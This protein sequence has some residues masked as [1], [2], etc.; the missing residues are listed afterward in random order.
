VLI[1]SP[2]TRLRTER[3][4]DTALGAA[5]LGALAVAAVC[6][7]ACVQ[8]GASLLH[9]DAKAHLVVA[10]RAIDSLTPGW[11]QLGAVWLPLPHILN[12]LPAQYDAL[13]RTGLAGSLLSFGF[14][15]TGLFT[16]ALGARRATG[17]GIAGIVALSVPA[18][19]PGWLYLQSTPLIE[20]MYLGCVGLC[21]FGLVAWRMGGR[22]RS[23]WLA[24][25][26]A[27]LACWVRYEAWPLTALAMLWAIWVAPPE[28]RRR[29]AL[30]GLGAG[31]VG[32]ILLYGLHSWAAT[33]IPFYAIGSENLTEPR[34][35]IVV[36]LRRLMTGFESAFGTPLVVAGIIAAVVLIV[37]GRSVLKSPLVP[38]AIASFAPLSVTLT[39]YIAGHPSKARY[40][41]LSAPGLALL[42]AAATMRRPILQAAA[43]IVTC[44]QLLVAPLPLPIVREATWDRR[45]VVERLP[46]LDAFRRQYTGGH[47][48][49]SMGSL[50]PVLFEL[51][52][53]GIPL[54]D[55]VHEGN[56]N[57]W[58][59]AVVDPAREVEWMIIAK[60]DVIDQERQLRSGYPEGFVPALR[61]GGVTFFRRAS[62]PE[63]LVKPGL[64]GQVEIHDG[65]NQK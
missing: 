27:G 4:G 56:G 35:Q 7:V 18:L 2:E 59:Y 44:S 10:R 9:F 11:T 52:Q 6:W 62:R 58:T 19:N 57:W 48:L 63:E 8:S 33:G 22:S 40:P 38:L 17:D 16:L 43:L 39:A 47:I 13:Y 30:V 45:D 25:L 41:L 29:T 26:G 55:F 37:R 12:A 54:R 53:R 28:S 46:V 65:R 21:V 42:L 23:L 60:G 15:A 31:V 1:Q 3:V 61:F 36:S 24:A 49:A 5:L 32:P 20:A 14:F 50:A 51:N 34:G 64:L